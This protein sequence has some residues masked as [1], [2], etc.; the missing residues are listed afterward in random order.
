MWSLE[1][2]QMLNITW[3][4]H[5][6]LR[7][8][9]RDGQWPDWKLRSTSTWHCEG[10]V[11]SCKSLSTKAEFKFVNRH[12]GEPVSRNRY[13][14][15]ATGWNL[16]N[17]GSISGRYKIFFFFTKCPDLHRV[18]HNLL[19]NGYIRHIPEGEPAR[20]WSWP[21]THHLVQSSKKEWSYTLIP[22]FWLHDLHR[23]NVTFDRNMEF[24]VN[25]LKC[26]EYLVIR[27][28]FVFHV[29]RSSPLSQTKC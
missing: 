7:P 28:I 6:W 22:P 24:T 15:Q 8:F 11:Q 5:Q 21:L 26:I 20:A 16:A 2:W 14:D 4:C 12:L 27:V 29:G 18:S 13:S 10:T 19:P 25:M 23:D 1:L 9:H 17:Q 3:Y